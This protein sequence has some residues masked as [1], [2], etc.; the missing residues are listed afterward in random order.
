MKIGSI[1]INTYREAIRSK[2]LY[3]VFFFAMTLVALSAVFGAVSI[4]SQTKVM[5]DFSLFA[6]S[7]FGVISCV[8][9]GVNLLNREI[10]QKTIYNILS[11]PVA[12]WQFVLGK[13]LG[14]MA[15][16]LTLTAITGGVMVGFIALFEGAVDPLLFQGIYFVM[17]EMVVVS[18]LVIFF[19]SL[20]I[21]TT[22]TA[23]FTIGTYLG[24]RSIP[25]LDYFSAQDFSAG[26][27]S[28]IAILRHVLPNLSQFN[29][30]DQ[31]VYGISASATEA[32][33]AGGYA[34]CWAAALFVGASA[35]FHFRE[36]Q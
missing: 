34:L 16:S 29:Y 3:A 15:V 10:K 35:I 13:Q 4:G 11:K 18:S 20:V 6:L 14:L 25:Y 1:A 8:A 36:L 9:T 23:L 30:A 28:V 17:L 31:L 5:K 24:G 19:S 32:L 21:T 26:T 7:F 2:I 22:L 27:R 12:R 33:L